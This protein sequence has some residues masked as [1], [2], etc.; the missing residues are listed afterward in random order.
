MRGLRFLQTIVTSALIVTTAGFG[1]FVA[2]VQAAVLYT[3]P[4]EP[5][6][7]ATGV[8]V[9]R[10]LYGLDGTGITIGFLSNSFSTYLVGKHQP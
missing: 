2:K 1:S 6:A 10:D 9:L 7:K 3:L 4:I 8:D 5:A